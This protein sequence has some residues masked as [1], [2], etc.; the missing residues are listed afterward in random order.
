MV[1]EPIEAIFSF[2]SVVGA[3]W[4][5]RA[6]KIRRTAGSGE[7]AQGSGV[8]RRRGRGARSAIATSIEKRTQGN[9]S[10]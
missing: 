1:V 6:A 4:R 2:A 3:V 10:N 8:A 7:G 5:A 9:Q